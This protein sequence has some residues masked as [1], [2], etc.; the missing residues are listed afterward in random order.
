VNHFGLFMGVLM[1][2]FIVGI[3]L[4]GWFHPRSGAQ[5]LDW[6]PTRSPEQEA[7]NEVDDL[8]QMLAATNEKRRRR[9]AAELTLEGVEGQ[10]ARDL[11]SQGERHGDYLAA[12]DVAQMLAVKNQR[13]ARRGLPAITEA[14]YRAGLGLGAAGAEPEGGTPPGGR[15]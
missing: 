1:V 7:E 14:E 6:K 9:G 8:A 5:T 10:V 15:G 11:H 4:L 2:A 12:Q 3:V 13:R